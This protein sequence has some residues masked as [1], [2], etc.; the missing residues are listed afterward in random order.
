MFFVPLQ[1]LQS[2]LAPQ[3]ASTGT[4]SRRPL[5]TTPLIDRTTTGSRTAHRAGYDVGTEITYV[6]SATTSP[7]T[8]PLDDY[9][10]ARIPHRRDQHGRPRQ[11]DHDERARADARDRR[12]PLHRRPRPRHPPHL[13]AEGLAVAL[14]GWLLG[15]PLGYAIARLFGWLLLEVFGFDFGFT[16][17]PLNIL[18][19]LAGT[20]AARAP[21]HAPPA[22]PRRPLQARRGDALCLSRA[23][24]ATLRP[25][26]C[27]DSCGTRL[28]AARRPPVCERRCIVAVHATLD[29]F[30][31]PESGTAAGDHLPRG[32]VR[33]HCSFS[34]GRLSRGLPPGG[35][36]RSPRRS[37]RSHS[38]A[39]RSRSPIR[40]PPA[41]RRRLERLPA[42]PGGVAL[43][44]SPAS[45]SGARVS[46][47]GCAGSAAP[48]R[49]RHRRG[50]L[51]P[52]APA[53]D[54]DPGHPPA[55]RRR[56]ARRPR[57]ASSEVT[58]RTA[59]GLDLHG[60]YAAPETAPP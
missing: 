47:A 3:T 52:R 55:P 2:V 33:S 10:R 25:S 39:P 6:G 5:E 9:H 8:G 56:R 27:R 18:I 34:Q 1:T 59:D 54:R 45:C 12:P 41:P 38:S 60:R 20:V 43:S 17:P 19:A 31:T 50:R 21:D 46:R 32:L 35:E 28:G 14:A 58:V 24:T 11:R 57:P 22:P 23:A 26:G 15:I 37:G 53:R 49:R 48:G 7:R 4:G 51:L 40:A 29:A 44:C 30:V 16:F 42:P 13:P 36:R